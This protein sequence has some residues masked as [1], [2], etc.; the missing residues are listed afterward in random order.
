MA[1]LSIIL[2]TAPAAANEKYAAIVVDANTGKTLYEDSADEKRYPASLTKMMTLFVLFEELKAGK[3]TLQSELSVSANAA[4]QAPSKLSLRAGSKIKVED[5]ILALTTKSANDASVVV[6]ENV[7]GSV[8][9][10][11]SA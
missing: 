2:V 6:A 7:S 9:H 4:A 10:S 1:I 3:F 5:A 11:P 8:S